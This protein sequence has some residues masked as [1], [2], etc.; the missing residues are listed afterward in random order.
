MSNPGLY[1]G[2]LEK[3]DGLLLHSM[4]KS[5]LYYDSEENITGG[6]SVIDK[7]ENDR[8]NSEKG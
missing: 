6:G 8:V 7:K 1:H 3:K 4:S 5:V 2:R